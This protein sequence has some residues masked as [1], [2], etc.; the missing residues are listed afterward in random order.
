MEGGGDLVKVTYLEQTS[1][2]LDPKIPAS[3]SILSTSVGYVPIR[4]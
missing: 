1:V 3:K 4:L 2:G